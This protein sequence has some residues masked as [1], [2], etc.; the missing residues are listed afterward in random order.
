MRTPTHWPLTVCPNSWRD[1]QTDSP[2]VP[3]AR[4]AILLQVKCDALRLEIWAV[5]GE[6]SNEVRVCKSFMVLKMA[7]EREVCMC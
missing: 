5:L 3:L 4:D 7:S 1:V 6:L 2:K